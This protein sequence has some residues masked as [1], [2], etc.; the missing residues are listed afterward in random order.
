MLGT[1]PSSAIIQLSEKDAPGKDRPISS[2]SVGFGLNCLLA[3]KIAQGLSERVPED[4]VTTRYKEG[5]IHRLVRRVHD[6]KHGAEKQLVLWGNQ[7]KSQFGDNK[8]K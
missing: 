6:M 8:K 1:I 4:M 5:E 3:E 7:D 2:L